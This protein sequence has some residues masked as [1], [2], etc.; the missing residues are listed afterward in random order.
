MKKS[1]LNVVEVFGAIFSVLVVLVFLSA[2]DGSGLELR[3]REIL[4]NN[5]KIQRLLVSMLSSTNREA[6]M[7][8]QITASHCSGGRLPEEEISDFLNITS[9][10]LLMNYIFISDDIHIYNNLS[11]VCL[12]EVNKASF[13]LSLPCGG[14]AAML[15]GTWP[16]NKEVIASC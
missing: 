7:L 4:V 6:S 8:E 2:G 9:D 1:Q 10:A 5:Q 3:A 14:S 15:L 16:K 12:D 13:N 11:S